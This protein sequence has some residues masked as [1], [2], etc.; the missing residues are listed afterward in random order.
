[1]VEKNGQA[2]AEIEVTPEMVEAGV[3][4]YL[5]EARHDDHCSLTAP[6]LIKAVIEAANHQRDAV[7]ISNRRTSSRA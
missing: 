3:E 5:S 7:S 6:E 2:G 4:I 1:M